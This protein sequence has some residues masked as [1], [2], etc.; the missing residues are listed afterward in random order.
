MRV[1]RRDIL[2]AGAFASAAPLLSAAASDTPPAA[3]EAAIRQ[4]GSLPATTSCLV[5][6]EGPGATW[7]ADLRPDLVLFIGSAVKTFIL[8]QCLRAA[9]LGQLSEDDQW[10]IDDAVRSP[11]SPA[12]LNLSGTTTG[13]HVLEAMITHSDNTATDTTLAKVGPDRVRALIAE[14]GLTQTRIP[15]S[16]RRL[17]SYLAGASVGEDL[18]WAGM[19]RLQSGWMPGAPRSPVNDQQAMLSSAAEMVR[20]YQRALGGD[21][22]SRPETLTEFKR[23]QAMADAISLVVPPGVKAY[24]KGGSIDW[25]RFHCFCIPGQMVVGRSRA[26]FCFTVN[27]T[28]PDQATPQMFTDF[29]ASVAAVLSAAALRT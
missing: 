5:V 11:A 12:F 14:A 20:W 22:F 28:A 9:E 4:F 6:H 26:S 2:T 18:G 16:T 25:E 24:A 7:Q 8:A 15:D 19:Q 10:A 1:N 13:R 23:I 3:V 27:W 29:K 21:F 17:F